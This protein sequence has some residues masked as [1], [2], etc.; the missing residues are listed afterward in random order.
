LSYA[1]VSIQS[2]VLKLKLSIRTWLTDT[3]E[4]LPCLLSIHDPSPK[5]YCTASTNN[6]IHKTRNK[7]CQLYIFAFQ[8]NFSLQLFLHVKVL[9]EIIKF[10][11][12]LQTKTWFT[13]WRTAFKFNYVCSLHILSHYEYLVHS[14]LY[15]INKLQLERVQQLSCLLTLDLFPYIFLILWA[16]IA[17]KFIPKGLRCSLEAD[18]SAQCF[19]LNCSFGSYISPTHLS[20]RCS[21]FFVGWWGSYIYLWAI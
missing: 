16:L 1:Y 14:L 11:R 5:Q 6:I 18:N 20:N 7:Q 12:S 10:K 2:S 15:Y 21:F 9:S 3:S 8:I 19:G 13:G 4:L 17:A